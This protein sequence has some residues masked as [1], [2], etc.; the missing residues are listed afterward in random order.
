MT[1]NYVDV[2]N[3]VKQ[4]NWDEAHQQIQAHTDPIACLIHGYLHRV[5][6]DLSNAQYWYTRANK[7]MPN[8]TLQEEWDRL[9]ILAEQQTL[10]LQSETK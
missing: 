7:N 8:N 5:E 6:G 2:L 1:I 4:G 3:T 9:Y 10:F